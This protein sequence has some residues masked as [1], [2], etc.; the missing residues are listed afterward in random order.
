MAE[1]KLSGRLQRQA[2]AQ[3]Q[4]ALAAASQADAAD[5]PVGAVIF[6]PD[7][8]V[9][10]TA[11]NTKEQQLDPTCHAE[12]NAIRQ[13]V[14]QYSDGWRLTDC[15]LVVTLEPCTMCAGAILAARLGRVIF[16]AFEPKTGA[17]GSLIDVLRLAGQ[18]HE[19]EVIGG[20][21]EA[22]CASLLTDFFQTKH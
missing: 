12:V 2:E 3:M 19:P 17:C 5:V 15:T 20:I 16:G 6:S 13:A 10:A 8:K 21:L 4:Q 14:K 11:W 9:L 1:R 7:G 22:E 18:L